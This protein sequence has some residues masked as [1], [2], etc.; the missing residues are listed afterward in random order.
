MLDPYAV[1][2]VPTVDTAVRVPTVDQQVATATM[3][4]ALEARTTSQSTQTP[5]QNMQA[6]AVMHAPPTH[7]RTHP[8]SAD[9]DQLFHA[10]VHRRQE[11]TAE[12]AA[13]P[14]SER[15]PP[16]RHLQ[17]GMISRIEPIDA[18]QSR[19]GGNVMANSTCSSTV[20]NWSAGLNQSAPYPFEATAPLS[21]RSAPAVGNYAPAPR[22][23][24][25]DGLHFQATLLPASYDSSTMNVAA[26][27]ARLLPAGGHPAASQSDDPWEMTRSTQSSGLQDL[28]GP[29]GFR[30]D[31]IARATE[32]AGWLANQG[33]T[34][35]PFDK[36]VL[37]LETAGV[38]LSVVEQDVLRRLLSQMWPP[39]YQ[40]IW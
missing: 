14:A 18:R 8:R 17:R 3:Q 28:I 16:P 38:Q 36:L 6:L 32:V 21:A 37:Q 11:P 26:A 27:P 24:T 2:R 33:R 25:P 29:P 5:T 34:G 19:S 15:S 40:N 22:A 31:A 9:P 7:T 35:I 1:G 4:L 20:P 39:S 13:E 12:P 10:E 30:G 23:L